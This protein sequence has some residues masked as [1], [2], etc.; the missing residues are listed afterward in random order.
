MFKWLNHLPS[1]W[2]ICLVTLLPWFRSR[3]SACIESV[4][5]WMSSN[6]LL[7]KPS[8]TELIWLGSSCRLHHCSGTGM[9]VLD[10]DL[11]SVDCDMWVSS[12]VEGCWVQFGRL[13][14]PTSTIIN[15]PSFSQRRRCHA[16]FRVPIHTRIS[17][18]VTCFSFLVRVTWLTDYAGSFPRCRIDQ[19][20]R[21]SRKSCIGSCTGWMWWTGW[22]YKIGLLVYN[23]FLV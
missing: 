1:S 16:L 11:R 21:N 20:W 4:K 14:L 2:C 5:S 17:T 23:V 9:R 12:T 7:L 19:L 22:T 6:R 3:V 18:T 8:K 10:V 15:H 13:L